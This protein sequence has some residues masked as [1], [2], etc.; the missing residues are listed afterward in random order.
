M[1]IAAIHGAAVQSLIRN[2]SYVLKWLT[3]IEELETTHY[4]FA[5]DRTPS[6]IEHQTFS[7][8]GDGIEC[9]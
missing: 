1:C 8:P 5:F 7:I 2:T 6:K 9:R 4:A 3:P